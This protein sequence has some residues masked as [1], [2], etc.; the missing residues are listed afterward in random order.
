MIWEVFM[1]K[2]NYDELLLHWRMDPNDGDAE[3]K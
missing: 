1:L 2:A 3:V